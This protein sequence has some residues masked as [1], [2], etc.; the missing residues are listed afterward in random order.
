MA[1]GT[2]LIDAVEDVERVRPE[3]DDLAVALDRPYCAPGWL[4]PWWRHVAPAGS[5]LRVVVARDADGLAGVAPFYAHRWRGVWRY[6]LLATGMSSRVEPIVRA[7]VAEDATRALVDVLAS[8]DP[9]PAAVWLHGVPAG[10]RWA[11]R[12]R[13]EWPGRGPF[14]RSLPDT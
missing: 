6:A 9:R 13:R 10:S 4:V 1:I 5:L 12:L 3:W 7:D 2:E 8:A 14:V 11:E